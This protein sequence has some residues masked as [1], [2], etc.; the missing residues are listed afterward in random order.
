MNTGAN[1]FTM[2]DLRQALAAAGFGNPRTLLASG[3]LVVEAPADGAAIER[4]IEERFGVRLAVMTR[5]SAEI[6]AVLT[7]SP[8]A[9]IATDQAKH[10]AAFAAQTIDESSVAAT[11][12]GDW[13]EERWAVRGRE[14]YL[15]LPGGMGRSPLAAAMAKPP[16]GPT[17]TVRNVNTIEKL[18]R[19]VE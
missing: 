6:A 17:V 18:A 14:L 2:A 12:S 10:F 1:R 5:T 7:G 4:V 16:F 11:L 15:W 9:T 8:F 13:G 19:M 3:N